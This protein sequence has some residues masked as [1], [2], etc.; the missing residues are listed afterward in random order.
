MIN[1]DDLVINDISAIKYLISEIIYALKN[2]KNVFMKSI[3]TWIYAEK[4][5]IEFILGWE[6]EDKKYCKDIRLTPIPLSECECYK[7]DRFIDNIIE[8]FF[9][10]PVNEYSRWLKCS[11]CNRP[12][13]GNIEEKICD[14]CRKEIENN[15][16]Q[17]KRNKTPLG[18]FENYLNNIGFKKEYKIGNYRVDFYSEEKNFVV[19]L[20]GNGHSFIEDKP[21]DRFIYKKTR[22]AVLRFMNKEIED[23]LYGCIAEIEEIIKSTKIE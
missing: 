11:K 8:F 18:F 17:D 14:D 21:R 5:F 10:M 12:M 4:Y 7:I 16:R 1:V 9:H 19:E 20:D 15:I 22:A 23:N 3:K 6:E 2:Y 13:H